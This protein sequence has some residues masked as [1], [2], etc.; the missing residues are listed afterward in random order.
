MDHLSC[1]EIMSLLWGERLFHTGNW[2]LNKRHLILSWH[3][4]HQAIATG[5]YD[6]VHIPGKIN[7]ADILL[8]SNGVIEMFGT[9]WSQFFSGTV[10]LEIWLNGRGVSI[11][12]AFEYCVRCMYVRTR[13]LLLKKRGPTLVGLTISKYNEQI[14]IYNN[15]LSVHYTSVIS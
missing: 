2:I 13:Y 14:V 15:A 9:C 8:A 11:G 3:Y 12:Y 7:P 1:S 4:V 5:T 10:T 6:Y